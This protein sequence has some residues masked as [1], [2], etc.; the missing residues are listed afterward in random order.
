MVNGGVYIAVFCLKAERRIQV[1]RLGRF[2]FVPGFYLY[3]GSAQRNLSARLERHAEK[4]KPL[5]WHIDHLSTK[6]D[7][8]GAITVP[9]SRERECELAKELGQIVD[10][11]V[12]HFGSSDCG[13]E[14]HLFYTQGL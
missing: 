3:V 11:A 1:G 6:A 9:D 14:G 13:C 8:I 5:R 12:P 4:A 10:L 2:V 7:M